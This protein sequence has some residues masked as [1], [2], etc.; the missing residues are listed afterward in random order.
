MNIVVSKDEFV[1]A[2]MEKQKRNKIAKARKE[3][4]IY[5]EYRIAKSAQLGK[6]RK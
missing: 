6:Y 4:E 1:N 2:F 3:Q 5:S